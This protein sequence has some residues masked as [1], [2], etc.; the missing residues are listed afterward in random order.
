MPN[1]VIVRARIRGHL[2]E[3]ISDN[4]RGI[5]TIDGV[6]KGRGAFALKVYET[7]YADYR[8]RV[9]LPEDVFSDA[10]KTAADRIDYDNFKNS[11]ADEDYHHAA[12]EVW[13]TMYHAQ[14]Y[15]VSKAKSVVLE[16]EDDGE[17]DL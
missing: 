15:D 10:V 11:I 3:F 6:K 12:L 14:L 16:Q 9:E 8:F 13:R 4:C 7:P 17:V 1:T 2:E 5:S